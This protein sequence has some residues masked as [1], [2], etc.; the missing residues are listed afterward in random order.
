MF[1]DESHRIKRGNEGQWCSAILNLAHLPTSKLIMSGTPLPNSISD[2]IPQF[3][4]LYPE[5]DADQENIKSLIRPVFVRT[6]KK[7]LSLPKII[8]IETIIQ[9]QPQQ[10][11]LYELLR[12]EEARKLSSFN[13]KDRSK[14]RHIS[15]SVMRLLQLTSNPA[16]LLKNS[17]DLPDELYNALA[18]GDNAK[19]EY[20]CYKARK[21]AQEG[22][23]VLIWSNFV[24]NVETIALRLSDIGADYIHGGVEAGSEEEENTRESK[25]AK[26]HNSSQASVLVANPAA[27]AEGISLH[28]VCHHAIYID[29]NYNAAQYLQSEDRIHRL[30]LP[31][32]V[33]T[34]IEILF[35]PDTIDESVKRRLNF[36]V[37]KMAEILDDNSLNIEVVEPDLDVEGLTEDDIND[38][39]M[40]L[41][42]E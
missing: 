4:F 26:F 1:L 17:V 10:R 14:L 5:I 33:I 41:K 29:R 20:A 35:T 12:S 15:R 31:P 16:L 13:I 24:E 36:K 25:I 11:H 2:I 3:N 19:I 6:T 27:C 39:L 37:K 34:T 28:T 21:L 40:H 18:E 7:E 30:G 9:L 8:R 42:G 23:K 38:F 32:D 22:K